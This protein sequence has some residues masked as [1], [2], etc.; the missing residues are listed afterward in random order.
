MFSKQSKLSRVEFDAEEDTKTINFPSKNPKIDRER[1]K[2]KMEFSRYK[3]AKEI[4]DNFPNL[5]LTLPRSRL[6]N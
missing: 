5:F 2:V 6:I 1:T 4:S 3:S